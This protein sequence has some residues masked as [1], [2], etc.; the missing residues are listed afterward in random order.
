MVLVNGGPHQAA[1][2]EPQVQAI[3]GLLFDMNNAALEI[4]M[5]FIALGTIVN[6][7][8]FYKANYIPRA[9]SVWGMAAFFVGLVSTLLGITMPAYPETVQAMVVLPII[10]FE[11]VVG[12]WLWF[13]GIRIQAVEAS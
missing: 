10:L 13:K 5:V 7:Y 9:L 1:L 2:G 4:L 12:L 11:V 6:F 3:V 8:L